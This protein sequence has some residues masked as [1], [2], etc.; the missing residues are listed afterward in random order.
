ML[1]TA[2]CGGVANTTVGDCLAVFSKA[3]QAGSSVPVS[4]ECEIP[5]V[6]VFARCVVQQI[7]LVV[8]SISQEPVSSAVLFLRSSPVPVD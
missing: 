2:S 7:N 1:Q 8:E 5:V 4:V 6:K 3:G